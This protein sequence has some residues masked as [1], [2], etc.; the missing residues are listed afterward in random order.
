MTC[1]VAPTLAAELWGITVEEILQRIISGDL[2]SHE[3]GGFLFIDANAP[4]YRAAD[5][6]ATYQT[7]KSADLVQMEADIT[8]IDDTPLNFRMA[9]AR[10][11]RVRPRAAA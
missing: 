2:K 1:W 9:R 11:N 5:R 4:R 7:L 8:P 6:P 3:D 10:A